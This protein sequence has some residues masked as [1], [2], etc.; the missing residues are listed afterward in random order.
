MYLSF[1][2]T[3][4]IVG[5][6]HTPSCDVLIWESPPLVLGPTGFLLSRIKGA[7]LV[8][9]ISDLWTASL[10]GLGLVSHGGVVRAMMAMERFLY[11]TSALVTGQTQYIID[12]VRRH[13]AKTDAVL[14]RNGTDIGEASNDSIAC[15]RAEWGI[16]PGQFVAGYAGVFGMSQG[17]EVICQAAALI[18][19]PDVKIVMVGDGPAKSR[20]KS[21][22]EEM[23][24]TN[25]LFLPRQPHESM[26]SIWGA[27]D[28][29]IVCLKRRPVFE[30]A[31]PSKMFEA[32]YAKR[33]I[34]L[35][36]EGEAAGILA[37]A[38]AGV[39]IEPENAEALASAIVELYQDPD[40]RKELGENGRRT[41]LR[42]Y[43]RATLNDRVI[44]RLIDA[45]NEK[46]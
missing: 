8:T 18:D 7:R 6:V 16:R 46:R 29:A 11:R 42:D 17:L 37:D 41:V 44:D 26:P 9:N 19:S 14:W 1:A 10:V 3:S 39:V 21:L 40:R 28:C 4:L 30:G 23:G 43:N 13:A 34:V 35:G 36:V 45:T 22:T 32:M 2:A 20:I 38:N 31:V 15:T 12:D 25:I 5:L 33:P 24:L 27:F